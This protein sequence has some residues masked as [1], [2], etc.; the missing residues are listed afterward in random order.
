[1]AEARTAARAKA[2]ASSETGATLANLSKQQARQLVK[3]APSLSAG[4]HLDKALLKLDS[5]Q[6]ACL[7]GTAWYQQYDEPGQTYLEYVT[8][9][10]K[11][12]HPHRLQQNRRVIYLQV[13][14][15]RHVLTRRHF[16]RI[17]PIAY[18]AMLTSGRLDGRPL[19]QPSDPSPAA[20]SL[21][22]RHPGPVLR[23]LVA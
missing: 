23:W 17:V 15:R 20:Y 6:P 11:V 9:A 16:N 21:H 5:T 19:P 10:P 3:K 8:T 4:S 2:K 18:R 13:S 22:S 7:K 14:F 12:M 1:M